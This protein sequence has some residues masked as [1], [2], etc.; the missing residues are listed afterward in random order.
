MTAVRARCWGGISPQLCI[1]RLLE[2]RREVSAETG[3]PRGGES[4][5][6]L[7]WV[8]GHSTSHG[9]AKDISAVTACVVSLGLGADAG[10]AAPSLVAAWGRR[11][12][13]G[14]R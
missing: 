3:V 8:A 10:G 9:V 2:E 7:R 6:A 4:S 13:M 11:S 5:P 14:S 1:D 12:T